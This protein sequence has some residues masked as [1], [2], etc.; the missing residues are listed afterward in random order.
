[1]MV[2]KKTI[3]TTRAANQPNDAIGISSLMVQE[4]NVIAEVA[5]VTSIAL[6]AFLH[7]RLIRRIGSLIK[8]LY[9]NVCSQAS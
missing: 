6:D 9:W 7:A 2:Y 5:E 1:M 3:G 8:A 4:A